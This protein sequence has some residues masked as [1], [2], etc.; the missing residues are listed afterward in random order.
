MSPTA[1]ELPAYDGGHKARAA[2]SRFLARIAR[3]GVRGRSLLPGTRPPAA[4]LEKH[5]KRFGPEQ[6]AETASEFG[7]AVA[8][9]RPRAKPRRGRGPS[10]KDRVAGYLQAGHGVDV[11]A[12]IENLSP[13]RARKLVNEALAKEAK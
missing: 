2:H 13:S 6:V 9:E 3:G 8:V 5:A 10:L 12:E 7:L 4:G 11:I 1:P